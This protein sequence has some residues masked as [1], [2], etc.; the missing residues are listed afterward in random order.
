MM[1]KL[2]HSIELNCVKLFYKIDLTYKI[3]TEENVIISLTVL[4][5]KWN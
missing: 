2:Q 1:N 3:I 4:I 5:L